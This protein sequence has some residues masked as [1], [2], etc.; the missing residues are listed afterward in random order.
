LDSHLPRIPRSLLRLRYRLQPARHRHQ[1]SR[2]LQTHLPRYHLNII[3]SHRHLQLLVSMFHL[4]RHRQ[5][6][7]WPTPDHHSPLHAHL[8]QFQYTNHI[9]PLHLQHC[10]AHQLHYL[11]TNLNL[12]LRPQRHD[13]RHILSTQLSK[14]TPTTNF[15]L[16]RESLL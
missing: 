1:L 10:R 15:L 8:F 3:S 11:F 2:P 5:Q 7:L 14:P 12:R 4:S 13:L 6:T 16:H 9:A